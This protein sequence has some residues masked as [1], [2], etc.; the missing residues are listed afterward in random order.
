MTQ[1]ENL[2]TKER[3]RNCR[4]DELLDLKW[5]KFFNIFEN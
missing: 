2:L 5:L 4:M 1:P 3:W